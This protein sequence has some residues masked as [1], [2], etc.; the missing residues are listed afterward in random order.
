[1]PNATFELETSSLEEFLSLLERREKD[2]AN[3]PPRDAPLLRRAVCVEALLDQVT[4]RYGLPFRTRYVVAAFAYGEDLITF[5][6][7]SSRSAEMGPPA[8]D[9]RELAAAQR[10]RYAE[11]LGAI[12]ERL[13]E[14]SASDHIP[15]VEG[16]LRHSSGSGG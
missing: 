7:V 8:D 11:V 14:M 9:E 1:V 6:S 3:A 5:K 10:R 4:S 2:A 12:R 15:L 16:I 13:G